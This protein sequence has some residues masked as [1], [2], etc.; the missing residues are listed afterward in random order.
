MRNEYNSS[1]VPISK[2]SVE[3][4]YVCMP[5]RFPCDA[6]RGWLICYAILKGIYF[7]ACIDSLIYEKK[8]RKRERSVLRRVE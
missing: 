5:F 4:T 1:K 2:R 3:D 8:Y 7:I 6:K